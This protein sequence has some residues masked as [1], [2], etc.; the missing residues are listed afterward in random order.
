MFTTLSEGTGIN[1]GLLMRSINLVETDDEDEYAKYK[2][3]DDEHEHED[4]YVHD[5]AD[6]EMKDAEDDETCL[7]SRKDSGTSKVVII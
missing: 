3:R 4:E 2:V 7:E 6:E 1:Q 5:G